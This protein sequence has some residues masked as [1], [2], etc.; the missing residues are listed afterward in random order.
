MIEGLSGILYNLALT[1]LWPVIALYYAVRARTDG[2]Y[3]ASCQRRLGLELPEPAAKS[4]AVW[5]H[6][7]SVGETL[8]AL[9]LLAALRQALPDRELVLSS[10]TESGHRIACLRAG[11]L[12]TR[13]FILAHDMLWSMS[14]VVKRIRPALF[15]LVETDL[16]PNLL[17]LLERRRVPMVLVNG[18]ISDRSL[19][20]LR[21][22]KPAA[23]WLLDRF[24]LICCQSQRDRERFLQLGA[25]PA[26]VFAV[27]NLKFDL[28]R[29][30]AAA[31]R[32]D[33]LR[34][35][36]DL[37]LERPVWIAGSTH[38]GEEAALLDAHRKLRRRH[39]DL[40]LIVAPRHPERG[41]QI[42][43]LCQSRGLAWG[44]RSRGERSS[45]TAVF[46]L[47][48]L[49][50]LGSCYALAR[51][52][53]IGGSLVPFGGHNPLEAAVHGVPCCWGPH[54]SNFREIETT[55]VTKGCGR[56]AASG[57]AV[58]AQI[59][60]WLSEPEL[61]TT[62]RA[63]CARLFAAEGQA[64]SRIVDL[65]TGLLGQGSA[66]PCDSDLR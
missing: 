16:W 35:E 3:R 43:T 26:R 56:M 17:W 13:R 51:A 62:A 49:G 4:G 40:L 15:V 37:S 52:A 58:A 31:C 38:P 65:M 7:L 22:L 57:A 5:V 11:R 33:Q 60:R 48:T 44:M 25:D 1:A 61:R 28:V 42:A 19:A 36:L 29:A 20:R 23:A 55:L 18:R 34:A 24:Q 53:F 64:A 59:D 32:V 54:L 45:A 12:S 14:A 6:A 27:G 39:P 30:Q 9:P 66:G 41:W 10:A 46:I 2:K 21:L 47:D 63:H 50:E 8:S